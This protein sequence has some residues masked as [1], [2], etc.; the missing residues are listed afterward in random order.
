M[1][2]CP[3]CKHQT[4]IAPK[5]WA[6]RCARCERLKHPYQTEQP[7]P[8]F[9]CTICRTRP[10]VIV[11]DPYTEQLSA[12]WRIQEETPI[13]LLKKIAKEVQSKRSVLNIPDHQPYV[14]LYAQNPK[15]PVAKTLTDLL[16]LVI[17]RTPKDSTGEENQ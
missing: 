2:T 6:M 1:V 12:D 17:L 14:R 7:E 8:P 9:Y 3:T 5:T 13:P 10:W 4:R 15:S 11:I 16:K